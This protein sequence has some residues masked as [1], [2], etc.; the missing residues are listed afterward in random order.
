[1]TDESAPQ[2]NRQSDY[3]FQLLGDIGFEAPVPTPSMIAPADGY[4]I[5]RAGR[6]WL[7]ADPEMVRLVVEKV[8]DRPGYRLVLGRASLSRGQA[9]EIM[10]VHARAALAERR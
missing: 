7:H 6:I 4:V 2:P 5:H 10:A 8:G 3:L 9:L 1:M